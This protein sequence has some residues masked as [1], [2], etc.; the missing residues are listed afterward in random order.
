[1]GVILHV[2][3]APDLSS[4][5]YIHI[6]IY[7]IRGDAISR[8]RPILHGISANFVGAV[9]IVTRCRS[10]ATLSAA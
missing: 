6:Y 4:S 5:L 10:I 3:E 7:T 9:V 2:L 8:W 1:M